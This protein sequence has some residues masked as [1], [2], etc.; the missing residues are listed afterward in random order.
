MAVARRRVLVVYALAGI[1]HKR[2]AEAL[3]VAMRQRGNI[4]CHIVD[5]LE[6][7]PGW[8]RWLYPRLYHLC[9]TRLPWV[10][11]LIYAVTS[12]AWVEWWQ[13]S[14]RRGL[15]YLLAQR[16]VAW[17]VAQRPDAV[18]STHFLPA[19]IL[20]VAKGRHRFTAQLWSVVTDYALHRFWWTP[21]TDRYFVGMDETR[22]ALEALGVL[23]KPIT[24]SGIPVDPVFGTVKNRAHLL[25]RYQLQSDRLTLLIVSGGAGIGPIERIVD[26]LHDA[27]PGVHAQLQVIAVAGSNTQLQR[28]L[29]ARVAQS[30]FPFHVV[31]FTRRMHQWMAMADAVAT[32]PGGLSVTEALTVGRPLVLF[33]P[34]PGQEAGNARLLV[35]HGVACRLYQPADIVP[36]LQRWIRQPH[37]FR[38]VHNLSHVAMKKH[39]AR[40]IAEALG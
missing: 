33:A 15:N 39:A 20:S 27:P 3:G 10:W 8:F 1:G 28:R 9:I 26:A 37:L 6:Y 38:E 32:K 7:M 18:I 40:T 29:Q 25:R 34:I 11:W 14:A 23:G 22:A 4:T 24:L 17:V 5:V 13:G 2:A 31:G 12:I 16:F 21:N 19:E 30:A 36:L 35:R